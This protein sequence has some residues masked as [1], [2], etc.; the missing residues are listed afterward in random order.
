[1]KLNNIYLSAKL[2]N[3]ENSFV[4]GA[5]IA[6][7][8]TLPTWSEKDTPPIPSQEIKAVKSLQQECQQIL[9]Q[10][11]TTSKQ[12]QHILGNLIYNFIATYFS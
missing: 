12:D 2:G 7:A 4:D 11:S 3:E 6:A 10:Y 8:R 9:S 5:V 1:M